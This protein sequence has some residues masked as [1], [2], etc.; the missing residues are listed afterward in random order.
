MKGCP[1]YFDGWPIPVVSYGD[2]GKNGGFSTPS[3]CRAG[4]KIVY[5][6]YLNIV[7]F[8][9]ERHEKIS[10]STPS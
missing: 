4:N 6:Y 1:C 9:L 5:L 8:L 2:T 7:V 10:G 3:T